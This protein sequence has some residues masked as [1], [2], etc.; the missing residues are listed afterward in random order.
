MRGG[1]R[2]RAGKLLATAAALVV[3]GSPPLMGGCSI[4]FVRGVDKEAPGRYAPGN[5]TTG[6]AAPIVDTVLTLA[7]PSIAL[8]AFG[9]TD[10]DYKGAPVSRQG[11]IV[12]DIAVAL[13]FGISALYGYAT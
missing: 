7:S 4:V 9:Q 8:H 5:C 3:L 13:L 10:E 2:N 1:I 11:V 12:G 6:K